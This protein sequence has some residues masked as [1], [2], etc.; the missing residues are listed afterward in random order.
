MRYVRLGRV[1]ALVR[2]RVPLVG[3]QAGRVELHRVH[4]LDMALIGLRSRRCR[5]YVLGAVVGRQ[6][7]EVLQEELALAVDVA[8]GDE[9]CEGGVGTEPAEQ[10]RHELL[11]VPAV[12]AEVHRA[13]PVLG[14]DG[15]DGG[16]GRMPDD[17]DLLGVEV[18]DDLAHLAI[19]L[20]AVGAAVD[21]DVERAVDG[22]EVE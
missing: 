12:A 5:R 3:V 14:R 17:E 15:V 9:R 21:H 6:L 4:V 1:P 7:G 13:A 20:D 2:L 19:A 10:L 18:G 8:D 16:L 22:A 11:G